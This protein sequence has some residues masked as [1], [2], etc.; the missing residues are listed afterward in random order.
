VRFATR[1]NELSALLNQLRWKEARGFSLSWRSNADGAEIEGKEDAGRNDLL[2]RY[3][4]HNS[5]LTRA[6]RPEPFLLALN[7]VPLDLVPIC[8]RP[9]RVPILSR[10]A[11]KE[12]RRS[13]R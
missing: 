1:W 9:W 10:C 2:L 11:T 5:C 4:S 7:Q 8:I 12:K 3:Q 6:Q 13:A